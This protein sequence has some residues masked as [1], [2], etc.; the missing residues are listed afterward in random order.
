MRSRE[1]HN[2]AT[3]AAMETRRRTKAGGRVG[4]SAADGS[5]IS[6]CWSESRRG[7]KE[8][9]LSDPVE[10]LVIGHSACGC[11]K[12]EARNVIGSFGRRISLLQVL[13]FD[14]PS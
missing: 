7:A 2:S 8:S 1:S 4:S 11:G 3:M 9:T 6:G 10:G 13:R 5:D 14:R 12:Y